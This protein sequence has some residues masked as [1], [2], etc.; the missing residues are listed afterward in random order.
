MTK[1]S[2]FVVIS[3]LFILLAIYLKFII[4]QKTFLE[5]DDAGVISLHHTMYEDREINI[6]IT[7]KL[8]FDFIISEKFLSEKALSNPILFASYIG[9]NWS[10]PPGQF[11]ITALII[12][13]KD[14]FDEKISKGKFLSGFLSFLSIFILFL[15]CK[16]IK[17]NPLITLLILIWFLLVLNQN[18]YAYHMGPYA[19]HVVAWLL[20]YYIYFTFRNKASTIIKLLPI[21][22]I[23][24]YFSYL[25][26]FPIIAIGLLIFFENRKNLFSLIKDGLI[27]IIS[28]I[29]ILIPVLVFIKPELADSGSLSDTF[30]FLD[31]FRSLRSSISISSS[32][33]INSI[34]LFIFILLILFNSIKN[35]N[36]FENKDIFILLF[37]LIIWIFLS[38]FNLIVLEE[39]RH[40]LVWSAPLILVFGI[41]INFFLDLNYLKRFKKV[42]ICGSICLLLIQGLYSNHYI[43]K[44]KIDVTNYNLLDQFNDQYVLV[45]AGSISPLLYL[46]SKGMNKVYYIDNNS[47]QRSNILDNLL[48]D[49][50]SDINLVSQEMEL[51]EYISNKKNH[52]LADFEYKTLDKIETFEYMTYNNKFA[53]TTPNNFYAYKMLRKDCKTIILDEE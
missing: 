47:F 42:L 53:I 26:I 4:G 25:N 41:L 51:V 49:C 14:T 36:K 17:I 27:Y 3:I 38:F 30:N 9:Y 19:M 21:I 5:F 43:F 39:S 8:K 46:K 37:P 31:L 12:N 44:K 2:F 35:K 28:S 15:I 7:D 24:V 48:S 32:D 22:S 20:L 16:K 23:S 11:L 34:I 33:T 1:N 50:N 40:V 52:K 6:E 45:Y 29:V 13:E 10:Y 18:L